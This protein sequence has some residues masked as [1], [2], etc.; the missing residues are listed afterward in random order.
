MVAY[1]SKVHTHSTILV[2]FFTTQI[3]QYVCAFIQKSPPSVQSYSFALIYVYRMALRLLTKGAAGN[4]S[5]H[6]IGSRMF[7]SARSH[8]Y[9]LLVTAARPM[10]T[11]SRQT[12]GAHL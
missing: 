10:L 1:R 5:N 3:S 12:V 9:R 2:P 8:I 11:A 6:I 4:H 7:H